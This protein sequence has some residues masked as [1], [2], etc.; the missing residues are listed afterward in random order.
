MN[1]RTGVVI[2]LLLVLAPAARAQT[3]ADLHARY[4]APIRETFVVRPGV[5]ATVSYDR[6]G[7]VCEIEIVP[8]VA[9]GDS[10]S[11]DAAIAPD[12]VDAL[13]DELAASVRRGALVNRV[14]AEWGRNGMLISVYEHAVVYRYTLGVHRWIARVTIQWL[15]TLCR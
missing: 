15:D 13:V 11:A 5:D 8:E 2:I 10:G 3:S 12:V 7:T 6:A 4:A 14:D 1:A 9:V